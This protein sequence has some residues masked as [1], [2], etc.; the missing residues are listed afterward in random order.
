MNH[1]RVNRMLRAPLPG[2]RGVSTAFGKTLIDH[3]AS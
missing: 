1:N 3:C 2:Y